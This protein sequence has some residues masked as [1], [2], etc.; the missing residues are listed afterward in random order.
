MHQKLIQ[1]SGDDV[2]II[3][4]DDSVSVSNAEPA[5]WEYQGLDCFSGKVWKEGHVSIHDN[6]QQ[7]MQ[8]VGSDTLF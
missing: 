5:Y 4:S 7:P 2:E 3:H 6:D 1:W 8:A